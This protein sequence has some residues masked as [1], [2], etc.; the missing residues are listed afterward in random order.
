MKRPL[1]GQFCL[2]GLFIHVP[3]NVVLNDNVDDA[4]I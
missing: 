2:K 3:V 4:N 1:K